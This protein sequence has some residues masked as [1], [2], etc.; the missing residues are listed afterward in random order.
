MTAPWIR[1][2]PQKVQAKRAAAPGGAALPLPDKSARPGVPA[3]TQAAVLHRAAGRCEVCAQAHDRLSLHHCR[4]HFDEGAGP[5]IIFGLELPD[6]L[7]ALCRPCHSKRHRPFGYYIMEPDFYIEP[8]RWHRVTGAHL[9][10]VLG[11]GLVPPAILAELAR[12]CDA[13]PAQMPAIIAATVSRLAQVADP[14]Q[15]NPGA[16]HA[17]RNP[18]SR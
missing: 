17:L 18:I 15:H 1:C 12:D 2:T 3:S 16:F 14:Q 7:L 11:A 6:D 10:A 5:R 13:A 8:Q 4:Y 9:S